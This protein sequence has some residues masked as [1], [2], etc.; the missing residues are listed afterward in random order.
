MLS[1]HSHTNVGTMWRNGNALAV[2]V[3]LKRSHQYYI[4]KGKSV[5]GFSKRVAYRRRRR[6]AL[7]HFFFC[8][9]FFLSSPTPPLCPQHR[10]R[11]LSFSFFLLHAGV[12][13]TM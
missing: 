3:C 9:N 12:H 7:L 11:L 13:T 5:V 8:V 10:Y 1:M 6:C 2:K 4:I